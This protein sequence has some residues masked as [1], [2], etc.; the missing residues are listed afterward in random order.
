MSLIVKLQE[1]QKV[2][3]KARDRDRLTVLRG[4]LAAVKNKQ[5]DSDKELTEEEIQKVIASQGKQLKDALKDFETAEREDLIEK[6]KAE[7]EIIETFLPKQLEDQ[8]IEVIAQDVISKVGKENFG[9]L[10]GAVMK[11]I[12]G[13]A[14]GQRVRVVVQK[15]TA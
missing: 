8:E 13:R 10:M 6:T 15:L 5:I 3:M 7:I 11:E 1:E 12:A 2:A 4:L 9:L 14:D